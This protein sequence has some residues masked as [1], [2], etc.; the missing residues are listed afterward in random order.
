MAT[1]HVKPA[2]YW[3]TFAALVALTALTVGASRLPIAEPWHTLIALTIAAAKGTL[4]GIFFMHLLHGPRL[5]WLVAL[6]TLLWLTILIG[7]T[8][9]DYL[10]RG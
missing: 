8:M 6:G 10:M 9:N 5:N 2:T 4:I 7:L 1:A 3:L